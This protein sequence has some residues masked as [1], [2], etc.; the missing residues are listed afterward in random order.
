V[1]GELVYVLVLAAIAGIVLARLYS[2]LGRRTGAEPPAHK[3]SPAAV[4]PASTGVAPPAAAQGG[5]LES[6][7]PGAEALLAADPN[8]DAR[9]FLTGA[10]AAY[11]IIVKAFAK[12]DRDTLRP[13][14]TERVFAAYDAAI[15][16]RETS[17][18]AGPEL[19][20]LRQAELVESDVDGS[21]GYVVVRF[22][23]QL[24]EG[25]TDVR[26]TKERW[27]FERDLRSKDPTWR[28]TAVAQA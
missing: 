14:L 6:P 8:F 23:A 12:G 15:A 9:H 21:V 25:E 5:Q 26:E 11:E 4:G 20:R 10:R 24:A 27:T 13:L 16:Q 19:I 28:L 18:G 22:E 3:A 2:V 7:E 1:S 17:G